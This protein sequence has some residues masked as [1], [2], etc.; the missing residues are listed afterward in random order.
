[1]KR[2]K[3]SQ[4]YRDF[5]DRIICGCTRLYNKSINIIKNVLSDL[6]SYQ[7]STKNINHSWK[8]SNTVTTCTAKSCIWRFLSHMRLYGFF[9]VA[10]S[11][12]LKKISLSSIIMFTRAIG[13]SAQLELIVVHLQPHGLLACNIVSSHIFSS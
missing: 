2:I 10:A 3:V 8:I 9:M 12:C 1:M 6:F 11:C 7:S 4:V 13:Q 5:S